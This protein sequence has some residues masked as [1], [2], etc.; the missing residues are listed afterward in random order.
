MVL[1]IAGE[2][3][4][5]RE[6]TEEDARQ[7]T[8]SMQDGSVCRYIPQIPHPYTAGH[9]LE[10]IKKSKEEIASGTAYPLGIELKGTSEI[11]G[12]MTLSKVDLAEKTAEVGYWLKTEYRGFGIASEALRI[13]IDFGFSGLGLES[14]YANVFEPNTASSGL[15][16]RFGFKRDPT[17]SIRLNRGSEELYNLTFRLFKDGH[18]EDRSVKRP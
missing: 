17:R 10:F 7:I 6:L 12:M 11:V 3:V 18:F 16:E 2:T 1:R 14:M 4:D 9:A 8:E 13:A 15:L 5:L